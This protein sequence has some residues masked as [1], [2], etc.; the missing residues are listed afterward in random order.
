MIYIIKVK[1]NNDGTYIVKIGHST[2]GIKERYQECK[3]KHKNILL[4]NCFQ[5][6][7]SY[8]FEKFLHSHQIIQSTNIK[9]L[10]DDE[11]TFLV[12]AINGKS[13]LKRKSNE[14]LLNDI[15]NLYGECY[16]AILNNPSDPTTALSDALS[17]Y[18]L[19]PD[20]YERV[21]TVILA[22]AN[23][24]SIVNSVNPST[25]GAPASSAPSG[26]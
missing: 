19:D 3:Q 14:R 5:V 21:K 22:F 10:S 16:N 18:S 12:E 13:S 24:P 2:K 15:F 7:K 17:F 1:T 8:E 11:V 23:D 26:E 4:L 9:N 6:D 20:F 25:Y